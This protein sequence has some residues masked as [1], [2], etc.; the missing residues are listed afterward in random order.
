MKIKLNKKYTDTVTGFTG[1]ATARYEYATGCVRYLLE[2]AD[3]KGDPTDFVVDEER[4]VRAED[5]IKPETTGA[6]GGPRSVPERS[7]LP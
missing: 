5:G 1:T 3:S 2:G 7:R 6:S 4:L